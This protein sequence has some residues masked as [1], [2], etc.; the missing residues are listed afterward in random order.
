MFEI[1]DKIGDF[2]RK[3]NILIYTLL[4]F[5]VIIGIASAI[6]LIFPSSG[7]S[8]EGDESS[9]SQTESGPLIV[10]DIR[11][12]EMVIPRYDYPVNTRD[13]EDFKNVNGVITYEGESSFGIDVS[14]YQGDIDWEKVK[15]A[16]VEFAFIRVGYRGYSTGSLNLD[17]QFL[18]NIKG[19]IENDI[20]VGVYFFSQAIDAKEGEEE[21]T[22]VLEQINSYKNDIDYPVVF[23][24][25]RVDAENTRTEKSDGD[26]ITEAANAFCKKIEMAGYDPMVYLNKSMGYGF[27]NLSALDGY[28]LWIAEYE[29][30]PSFYYNFDVWQYTASGSVDGIEGDVDINMS[31]I[32]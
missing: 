9:V 26:T 11:S 14:E 6:V 24:W 28:P 7:E 8:V 3:G 16:G 31:F 22:F 18:A 27:Y 15:E 25:E 17:N 23:D 5:V 21:A 20:K 12:G 10:D 4:A 1:L 2:F 30:A 19:A 32:N 13:R 29:K